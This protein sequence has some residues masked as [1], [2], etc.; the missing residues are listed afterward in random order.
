[1][2]LVKVATID[3][4]LPGQAKLVEV[5]GNEIAIFN[6]AGSFHAIDNSCTHVG[7]PL[8]EGEIAGSEVICPWHGAVFDVTT[9]RAV[10]PPAIEPLNRYRVHMEGADIYLDIPEGFGQ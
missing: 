6:L 9:G 4:I 3:E 1:M 2:P 7:G 5:D 10:G 8:C